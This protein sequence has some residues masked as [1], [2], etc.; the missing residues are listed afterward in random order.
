MLLCECVESGTKIW[1]KERLLN[2]K[3]SFNFIDH[4]NVLLLLENL[5]NFGWDHSHLHTVNSLLDYPDLIC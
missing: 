3:Y 4:Q 1:Y 2:V 5:F